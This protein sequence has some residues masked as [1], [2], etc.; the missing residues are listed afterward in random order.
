MLA[1]CLSFIPHRHRWHHITISRIGTVNPSGRICCA[2][3]L[4]AQCK[5][6]GVR[7]HK[8]FYRDISDEQARR[9]L[10]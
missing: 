4:T 10:G 9:W 8:V 6:C 5:G 2:T 3:H 7:I 1:K